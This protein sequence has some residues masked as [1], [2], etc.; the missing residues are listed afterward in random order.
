[1]NNSLLELHKEEGQLV[2][3]SSEFVRHSFSI[4]DIYAT[5][6][7]LV[8]SFDSMKY[9]DDVEDGFCEK[10]FYGS[11]DAFIYQMIKLRIFFTYIR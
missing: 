7:V 5:W 6:L 2:K 8:D 9:V 4:Y 10:R 3:Q 11:L 1:M